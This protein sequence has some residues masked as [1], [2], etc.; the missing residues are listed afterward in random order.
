LSYLCIVSKFDVVSE[1]DE[2]NVDV[3]FSPFDIFNVSD[4]LYKR[5]L[6]RCIP[7][8]ASMKWALNTF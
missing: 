7:F 5:S 6:S 1:A 4:A 2:V 8:S 3:T